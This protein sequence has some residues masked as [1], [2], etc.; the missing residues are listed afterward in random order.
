MNASPDDASPAPAEPI[1]LPVDPAQARLRWTVYLILIVAG[2]GTLLGRIMA[3]ESVDRLGLQEARLKE[4][5][6]QLE[7]KAADLQQKGL[8]GEQLQRSLDRYEAELKR[9][10]Q[11]T[12]P[13]LSANDRSRWCAVRA[14]VEPEMRVEGAPYAIDKVIKEPNWDTIDMVKHDGHLYSSK[15]PLLPTLMAGVYWVIKAATGATLGTHP[16]YVARIMLVLLNLLPMIAYFLVLA[17]LAERFGKTDWGRIFMMAAGVFG[18]LL[19]TFAVSVNNHLVAAVSAAVALY[20]A[21][22]IFCDDQKRLRYYALAG[23]FGAFAA[24]NELPAL[25]FLAPLALALLWERPKESLLAFLPAV[26]LVAV[27]FFGTNYI[28]HGCLRP[29]YMHRSAGDNWYDFTYERG[30]KQIKGYW[31]KPVGLDAGEA[32]R[33]AYAFHVLAGHHGIFSLTPIWALSVIGAG[34]W[35]HSGLDQRKRE[36]AFLIAAISIVCLVF[37]VSRPQVDRNYGGMSSGLRW[38]FWLAPLWLV[39]MLP[40][41]DAMASRRWMRGV[42]L[43]LLLFSA[44]SVAYP[45]WNPWTHPWLMDYLHYFGWIKM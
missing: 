6:A 40:A 29:P 10:A 32:S 27:A 16:F 21:V 7:K 38:M 17:S 44:M 28:A 15:P 26:A 41:L 23:F 34:I 20:A 13:F 12:R 18:T 19:T 4:I 22:R 14:L 24:A 3:V 31:K 8:K 33:S 2:A 1:T 37:Y 30:G 5:P 25:A 43:A 36:L 35:L 9:R 39:V 42:G 45:T 11:V